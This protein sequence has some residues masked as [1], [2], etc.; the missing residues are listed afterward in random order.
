MM[1]CCQLQS[2]ELASQLMG[3]AAAEN[4]APEFSGKKIGLFLQKIL[5]L[6][7]DNSEYSTALILWGPFGSTARAMYAQK[8]TAIS[9]KTL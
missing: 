3:K 8:M 6:K 1:G 7:Q 9:I 5:K 4:I 2:R